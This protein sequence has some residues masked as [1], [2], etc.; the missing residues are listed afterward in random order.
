MTAVSSPRK[1]SL[2]MLSIATLLVAAV[3]GGHELAARSAS[4]AV[5]SNIV[6][7]RV[8]IEKCNPEPTV[9]S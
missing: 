5:S 8:P 1:R 7:D 4:A 3:V 2:M 6:C 9:G